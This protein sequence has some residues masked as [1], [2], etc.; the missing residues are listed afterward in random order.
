MTKICA[1][2]DKKRLLLQ[3]GRGILNRLKVRTSFPSGRLA[4][5]LLVAATLPAWAG[6]QIQTYTVSKEHPAPQPAA[7]A[8]ATGSPDLPIN[9]APIHWAVPAGWEEKPA[10][11][12]RLGS[13]AI[14]GESG[15]K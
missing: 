6:D 2:Y 13:F 4:G 15:G 1:K 12:I 8:P 5:A 11:G 3:V 7:A 14:K 9:A 10:D